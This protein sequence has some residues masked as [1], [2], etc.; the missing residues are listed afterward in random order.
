VTR[1]GDRRTF[2]RP[3][4]GE[5]MAEDGLLDR[6]VLGMDAA[7][8]GYYAVYGGAPGLSWLLDGFAAAMDERGPGAAARHQLLVED[9]AR[10]FAFASID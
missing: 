4:L 2:V 9:P 3:V 8:R 5:W 7:R 10:V 1:G 6:V